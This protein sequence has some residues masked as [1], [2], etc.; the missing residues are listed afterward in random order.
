MRDKVRALPA[1]GGGEGHRRPGRDHPRGRPRL[2]HHRQ[3]RHL[4]H[5]RH[6]RAHHRHRQ[7]LRAVEPG[8]DDRPPGRALGRHEPAARPEQRP[9]RQRRRRHAGLLPRLPALA[10]TPRCA[11]SSPRA[12]GVPQP[13]T[14]GLN[15]NEMMKAMS[16]GEIRGM[17]LMGEDIV[18]SEPNVCRV[19]KA[20]NDIDFLVVQDI[21]LNETLPLRR[22]HP[23]RPP[24]SPR[25][26]ACSPTPIA[27]CSGC[28]RRSTRPGRRAPTGRSWST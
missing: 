10:T 17:Y 7:R 20:L 16:K 11:R 18:I 8:A 2:R 12:W 15:L 22:R 3:G 1:R 19:E 26:T 27:G 4:L 14:P 24:A 6:H 13:E 5:P 23:A 25:R 28:A 9:G 21:F